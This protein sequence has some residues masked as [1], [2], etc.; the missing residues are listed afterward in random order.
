MCSRIAAGLVATLLVQQPLFHVDTRLVVVQATVQ[1]T[2]GELVTNL[3]RDAFTVYE[4]GKRQPVMLFGREDVPVSIGLLIDNSGSMR[5]LRAQVEAAALVFARA[6]NPRDEMFVLN[7]ADRSRVDVPFTSDVHVL[8]AG[9]ARVDSIGGTAMWDAV[10]AAEAYLDGGT[11][12]RKVLV[13]ITDGGDNASLGNSERVQRRAEHGNVVIDAIGLFGDAASASRARHELDQLAEHTGGIAYYPDRIDQ[14]EGVALDLAQQ[15]RKQY[16]IA[17][18]PVN[19]ALDGTY[20]T[21]KVTVAAKERMVV[22]T[23]PGYRATAP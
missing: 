9:I 13:V 10:E 16:T 3:E 5:A 23:R 20:R 7:F 2:R 1:N 8:E 12:D 17:Y 18:A 11:R 15:I 6:S 22:R 19:Q 21:I 14:I 4:N